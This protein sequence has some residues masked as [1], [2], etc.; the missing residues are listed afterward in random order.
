[1]SGLDRTTLLL[2]FPPTMNT[3]WRNVRGKTLISKAGR[4]YRRSVSDRLAMRRGK[5]YGGRLRVEVFVTVPDR[6]RRD[7]DNMLKPLLDALQHGGLYADDEQIDDLRIRRA[8]YAKDAGRVS[9]SV[10]PIDPR[11]EITVKEAT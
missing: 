2:P 1:M 3:Y 4:E 10:E 6:R 9:V 5:S 7:L 8:G 11:V